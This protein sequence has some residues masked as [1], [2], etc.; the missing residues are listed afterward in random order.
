VA[1]ATTAHGNH[2]ESQACCSACLDFRLARR[3]KSQIVPQVRLLTGKPAKANP[4]NANTLPGTNR[5]RTKNRGSVDL[6][7]ACAVGLPAQKCWVTPFQG[8]ATGSLWP[9]QGRCPWLLQRALAGRAA[10]PLHSSRW[11]VD[12]IEA[13]GVRLVGVH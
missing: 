6:I 8:Q 1:F 10:L 11:S 7:D 2:R 12:L 9:F 3:R 5:T 4:W 13:R